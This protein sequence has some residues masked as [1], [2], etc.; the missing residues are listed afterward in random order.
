MDDLSQY[1]DF[2]GEPVN[3]PAPV[4]F[5]SEHGFHAA[6]AKLTE[7]DR[8]LRECPAWDR[9]SL[10]TAGAPVQSLRYRSLMRAWWKVYKI[11]NA[12]VRR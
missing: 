8:K 1:H 12:K 9:T 3:P 4:G 11:L 6:S 5:N 2:S 7:I 10:T